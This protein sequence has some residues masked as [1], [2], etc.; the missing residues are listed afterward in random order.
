MRRFSILGLPFFVCLF[1]VSSLWS[2]DKP[3]DA[4]SVK[5]WGRFIDPDGDCKFTREQKSVTLHVPATL[6]NL[7]A[8]L[9]RMNA[10]RILMAF[11]GDFV[12]QVKVSG[13]LATAE[14]LQ[15]GR[16]PY[17]AAGLL[18]MHDDAN[19]ITMMRAVAGE[20]DGAVTRYVN[21]ESRKD[22]Q[23]LRFGHPK[24][25]PLPGN[26][27]TWLRIERHGNTVLGSA[28]H[29]GEVWLPLP[30]KKLELP[31]QVAIG[32]VAISSTNIPFD[33]KFSDLKLFGQAKLDE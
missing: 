6:H 25:F 12:L 31:K 32:V 29:D 33:P 17:Q 16:K 24:E 9:K 20:A 30:P 14:T 4:K 5:G 3:D 21:F 15:P 10:P 23:L 18:L 22:G 2:Q 28:S 26:G 8:E 7:S 11:E 27:D 13:V 1:A 19:Y